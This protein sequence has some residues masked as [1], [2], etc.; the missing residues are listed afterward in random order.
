M[1]LDKF[2]PPKEFKT[3]KS[4]A[5]WLRSNLQRDHK[6]CFCRVVKEMRRNIPLIRQVINR[7]IDSQANAK[8]KIALISEIAFFCAIIT[9]TSRKPTS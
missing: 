3:S 9:I 5:S 7:E 8:M 6:I 1:Q 4:E 2:S